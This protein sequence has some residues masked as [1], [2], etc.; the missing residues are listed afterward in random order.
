MDKEKHKSTRELA[1]EIVY[2]WN[3]KLE[4]ETD[5]EFEERMKEKEQDD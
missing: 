3:N 4:N 5:E 2:A 1:Q